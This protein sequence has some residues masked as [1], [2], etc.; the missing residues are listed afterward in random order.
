MSDKPPSST[1][2]SSGQLVLATQAT[3]SF[4]DFPKH[5]PRAGTVFTVPLHALDIGLSGGPGDHL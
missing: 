5:L 3:K 4:S 1:H 2:L